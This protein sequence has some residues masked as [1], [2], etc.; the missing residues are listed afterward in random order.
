MKKF[1][2]SLV[3]L[4][5]LFSFL[6]E[7][8][9]QSSEGTWVQLTSNPGTGVT[10][11]AIV[12]DPNNSKTIYASSEPTLGSG[13][14]NSGIWK[15]IDG[16]KSWSSLMTGIPVTCLAMDPQNSLAIFAGT[17]KCGVFTSVDGGKNWSQLGIN[18]Q[19]FSNLTINSITYDSKNKKLYAGTYNSL[20]ISNDDGENWKQSPFFAE[21]LTGV[22]PVVIDPVEPSVLYVGVNGLWKS[23]D[24]GNNWR[25]LTNFLTDC[26]AIALDPN[27]H[28]TIYVG[29]SSN[30]Y[31]STD[32]GASWMQ[33]NFAGNDI[34]G[35][36]NIII[37]PQNTQNIYV[38]FNNPWNFSIYG[39]YKS[40][41]GGAS[42]KDINTG[43]QGITNVT[44]L[45]IDP[46]NP[47]VLY[48]GVPYK[49][50]YEFVQ[51]AG[52]TKVVLRIGYSIF[53]VD[54]FTHTLDSP[55][56]IINNRTLLPIRAVI[57]AIGGIVQWDD[58]KRK[59]TI[60]LDNN[61]IELWIGKNTARVNGVNKPIDSANTK[62][63][64]M[65]IN[66]RTMLP[67]RFIAENLGCDVVWN[68]T[69]KTIIIRY[70]G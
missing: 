45:A 17:D 51:T 64:P 69:T 16:G 18:D 32:G 28:L 59:V 56:V 3:L 14:E 52:Y 57:E 21:W 39:V 60:I 8:N 62:V 26:S 48:A 66:G 68:G 35:I 61:T 47:K 37:D 41:N 4:L 5:I 36:N 31:K 25:K 67:L 42:W 10:I 49:G 46:K 70:G 65:I 58:S 1:F 63:V 29:A 24:G 27:D 30:L 43:F 12:V 50:I 53:F 2:V 15:T 54:D 11:T 33:A 7:G 20:W 38:A 9:I 19:F 22:G 55:P 13:P 44:S 6:P 34:I 40:S 23:T